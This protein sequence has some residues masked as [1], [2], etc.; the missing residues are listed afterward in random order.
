MKARVIYSN[1]GK[2]EYFIEGKKVSKKKFDEIVRSKPIGVPMLAGNTPSAWPM[3]S[4][5]LAIHPS[6]IP[7]VMER[8]K[9][10]GVG[11]VDYDPKDGTAIIADRGARRKLME[12]DGVH[13][14]EGGFG[15]DHAIANPKEKK[16]KKLF[17]L[18]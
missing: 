1:R 2:P 8:N 17:G 18:D 13:D 4:D 16:K 9:R 11:G 5:A 3:R 15:D 6:Q 7:A 14:N 10:H 12:V